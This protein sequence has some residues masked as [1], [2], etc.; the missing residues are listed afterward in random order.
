MKK[1]L[2]S[3]FIFLCVCCS[4]FLLTACNSHECEEHNFI[5]NY[6]V[7]A[8]CTQDGYTNYV[9][10]VC[11]TSYNQKIYATHSFEK[12]ITK[13]ATCTENGVAHFACKNCDYQYDEKIDVLNHILGALEVTKPAKC[14]QD[15]EGYRHCSRCE[16]NIVEAIPHINHKLDDTKHCINYDCDYF[17]LF[18]CSVVIISQFGTYTE[19]LSLE[20]GK[21][22]LIF[23]KNYGVEQLK[24]LGYYSG[25]EKISDNE[26]IFDSVY[27]GQEALTVEAKYYY[28]VSSPQDFAGLQNDPLILN[29][30]ENQRSNNSDDYLIVKIEN[31]I[32]FQNT[33]WTPITVNGCIKLDGDNHRIENY[34]STKGGI[35]KF[36]KGSSTVVKNIV[37]ENANLEISDIS[38][39][40]T[41]SDYFE[42]IG[43][44]ANCINGYVENITVKSGSIVVAQTGD[45]DLA[46]ASICGKANAVINCKNYINITSNTAIASGIVIETIEAS[47]CVNYGDVT[48]GDYLLSPALIPTLLGRI[49][50]A[51]GIC[52]LCSEGV[53]NCINYGEINAAELNASGIVVYVCAGMIESCGNYAKISAINGNAAGIVVAISAGD[54]LQSFNRG[55]IIAKS[56]AG[57]IAAM[58]PYA[59]INWTIYNCYNIADVQ[60]SKYA[61]GIAGSFGS[62]SE[63]IKSCYNTGSIIGEKDCMGGIVGQS[64]NLS[65]YK[66]VNKDNNFASG[67]YNKALCKLSDNT[68]SVF[69]ELGYDTSIWQFNGNG[70]PTLKW[71][72]EYE[73]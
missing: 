9:C 17:E 13:E 42:C 3:I 11:G 60:S 35:F 40:S 38:S 1:I 50:G 33:D 63:P 44:L 54:I 55:Q 31:D 66:C 70:K 61:G 18:D 27:Q 73:A 26:G 10:S 14:T 47:K 62:L 4:I 22:F 52:V 2:V 58:C 71:E 45:T 41:N 64:G 15:G 48:A 5:V 34:Y 49:Y 25:K 28:S 72:S 69:V 16:N 46:V 8:T 21:Q 7:N 20:Y 68:D 12:T 23:P 56:Y 57:G 37:F 19:N 43:I 30:F 24:F 65:L 53:N 6:T 39:G 67:T 29:C 51:S 32:D 59:N 36:I